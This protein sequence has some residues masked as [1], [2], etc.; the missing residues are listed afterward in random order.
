MLPRH[1][2]AEQIP[3]LPTNAPARSRL[4]RSSIPCRG[5]P[6][7]SVLGHLPAADDFFSQFPQHLRH[8][9][10]VLPTLKQPRRVLEPGGRTSEIK[11][12]IKI[13]SGHRSL[14]R[15][16]DPGCGSCCVSA[17]DDCARPRK[18]GCRGVSRR[19]K[20]S[21]S[22]ACG[23]PS[24]SCSSLRSSALRPEIIAFFGPQ[25]L[26]LSGPPNPHCVRQS[27]H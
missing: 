1:P 19:V 12:K 27:P 26:R 17:R 13:V 18:I 23:A 8:F 5:V 9:H 20:A 22:H 2:R 7:E 3:Q 16:I 10:R 4:G 11:A 14:P 25:S 21:L 24:P 15:G 6:A